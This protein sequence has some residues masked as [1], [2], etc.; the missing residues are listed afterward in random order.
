MGFHTEGDLRDL[1]KQI[2]DAA[3]KAVNRQYPP[4]KGT[5]D[6]GL[7]QNV[8]TNSIEHYP[9]LYASFATPDP[10]GMQSALDS[11]AT[12]SFAISHKF[13]VSG[14]VGNDIPVPSDNVGGWA[15]RDTPDTIVNHVK[16]DI[17]SW[18]GDARDAFE[19]TVLDG[20]TE[21]SHNQV[22]AIN[23]LA[24]SLAMHMN[25]R[26]KLN[27]D[28]WTVG[29]KAKDAFDKVGGFS[30]GDFQILLTCV[31]A[32]LT[33]WTVWGGVIAA[34]GGIIAGLGAVSAKDAGSIIN[35]FN[36]IGKAS[37][38]EASAT[39]ESGT[40][41]DIDASM[42][43]ILAS[44]AK[45]YHD[46]EQQVVA[47]MN[48]LSAG[49]KQNGSLFRISVPAEVDSLGDDNDTTTLFPHIHN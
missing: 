7:G 9:D 31:T 28:V 45:S 42:K 37:S 1:G 11:L 20:F 27:D 22:V 49:M 32:A 14:P 19:R 34:E 41:Q 46:Q 24:A 13:P 6:G 17:R 10:A 36:N 47:A 33:V 16:D 23:A 12:M 3:K 48:Q 21:T 15:N 40:V 38:A 29:Q 35:G 26:R 8:D 18:H 25:L 43:K 39:L 4:S 5:I 44:V 30:S 2:S